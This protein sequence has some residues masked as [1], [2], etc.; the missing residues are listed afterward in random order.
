[1]SIDMKLQGTGARPVLIGSAILRNLPI[2][3]GATPLQLGEAT[4]TF[5]EGFPL[6]PS[7]TAQATGLAF[8]EP[9][10]VYL[11]GTAQHPIRFYFFAPPLTERLIQLELSSENPDPPF[12]EV[13]RFGLRVPTELFEGV[14]VTEWPPIPTPAP[15]LPAPPP[16]AVQ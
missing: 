2:R 9:F 8:G 1:V 14:E 16:G 11:T 6:N 4:L 12:K 5:R 7:I 10:G 13:A 3:C 15:T